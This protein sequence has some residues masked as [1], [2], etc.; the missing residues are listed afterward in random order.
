MFIIH[1]FRNLSH[2]FSKH[3]VQ[4]NLLLEVVDLKNITAQFYQVKV[5]NNDGIITFTHE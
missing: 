4:T 3:Y 5:G 2:L 1:Q